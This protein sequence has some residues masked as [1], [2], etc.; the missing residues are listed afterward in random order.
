MFGSSVSGEKGLIYRPSHYSSSKGA[1]GGF[2]NFALISQDQKEVYLR[3]G[4]PE[5]FKLTPDEL[6][7]MRTGRSLL[8][9]RQGAK[10]APKIFMAG[11]MPMGQSQEALVLGE[12]EP[13]YVWGMESEDDLIADMP[14]VVLGPKG[15]ILL[16]LP[17]DHPID[18]A[19]VSAVFKSAGAGTIEYDFKGET[20]LTGYWRL[21]LKYH[22]LT[23]G[24]TVVMSQARSTVLA[25][26]AYFKK[27]FFLFALLT[28]LVVCLLS[29]VLIRKSL[30][31]I[32]TP[33]R[34]GEDRRRGVRHRGGDP[35]R[36]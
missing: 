3:E 11:L 29:V 23:P 1:S 20:Y 19:I 26:V 35:E 17:R 9:V 33:E 6:D 14:L 16:S 13:N 7:H 10:E 22:F 12:I 8:L 18:K 30:V 24:W 36:R 27:L 34:Y 21:F 15:E 25:P 5:G 4:F 31:P 28:F 32:E 2:K